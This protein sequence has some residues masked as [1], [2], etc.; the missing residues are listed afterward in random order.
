MARILLCTLC[1]DVRLEVGNK[2]TLVGLFDTFNVV[3]FTQPLPPFSIFARIG[4][5]E[6][7]QHPF[8]LRLV[9]EEGDFRVELGG[10]LEARTQ[11]EVTDL[12][13]GVVNVKIGGMRLPR[14][15]RYHVRFTVDARELE[16]C[17]F[18]VRV[19]KPPTMQ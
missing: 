7:G 10:Q 6:E 3:D 8:G 2:H 17:S 15:G 9:S 11:S 1:D 19:V 5:E 13:E 18:I 16:G 14:P 12:F 4:L